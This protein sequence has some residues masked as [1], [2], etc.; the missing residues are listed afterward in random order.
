MQPYDVNVVL[1]KHWY[2]LDM[3]NCVKLWNVCL[4][5]SV[6]LICHLVW[7]WNLYVSEDHHNSQNAI[8]NLLTFVDR[9]RVHNT[10]HI[11]HKPAKT[12]CGWMDASLYKLGLYNRNFLYLCKEHFIIIIA[13]KKQRMWQLLKHRKSLSSNQTTTTN[14]YFFRIFGKFVAE[15]CHKKYSFTKIWVRIFMFMRW[16]I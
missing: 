12:K 14:N 11:Y 9:T 16:M 1:Y 13:K 8:R 7:S 5:L 3:Y 10:M 15:M 6:S 2:N 4:C